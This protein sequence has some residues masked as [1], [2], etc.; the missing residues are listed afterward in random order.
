MG[1][2]VAAEHQIRRI[3]PNT[4]QDKIMH[5]TR[6]KQAKRILAR[7]MRR[8]QSYQAVFPLKKYGSWKAAE[9]AAQKWV[10]KKIRQL[11]PPEGPKKGMLTKRNSSGVV[12]VRLAMKRKHSPYDK[13][14]EYWYW[15][16]NWPT[17]PYS[18]GVS[19]P[20]NQFG[21]N[22]AFVLAVLSRQN[23]STDRDAMIEEYD[24]IRSTNEY[25]RIL[26]K[27]MLYLKD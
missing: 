13:T 25:R 8:N 4:I 22:G 20:V 14:Y 23:E 10:R 12:G 21:D 9:N 15:V 6:Q 3:T 24:R 1:K 2:F 5:T 19:W 17:C 18:G 11:P 26:R 7:V 27:K 16:A